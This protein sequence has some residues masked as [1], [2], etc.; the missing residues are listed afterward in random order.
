MGVP[1]NHRI[2]APTLSRNSP[3]IWGYE[4]TRIRWLL[5]LTIPPSQK[6]NYYIH[7]NPPSLF[8]LN[9]HNQRNGNPFFST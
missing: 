4:S 5:R 8:P 6:D 1:P 7:S 3:A 9:L 2:V